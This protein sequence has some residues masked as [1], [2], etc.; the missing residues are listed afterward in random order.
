M[1][2]L[3]ACMPCALDNTAVR[4]FLVAGSQQLFSPGI[5]A[6]WLSRQLS[7]R[8]VVT[9]YGWSEDWAAVL[10]GRSGVTVVGDCVLTE[11]CVL[12]RLHAA[13]PCAP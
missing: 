10:H 6:H 2:L 5:T 1:T 8:A 4:L 13:Q 9:A 3:G 7:C 12:S 11:S